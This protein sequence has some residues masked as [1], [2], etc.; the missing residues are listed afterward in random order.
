MSYLCKVQNNIRR[1]SEATG[2]ADNFTCQAL[3]K[4]GGFGDRMGDFSEHTRLKA[5]SP[6]VPQN[7]AQNWLIRSLAWDIDIF[8]QTCPIDVYIAD[9]GSQS[10]A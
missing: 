3:A 9:L 6:I 2:C 5:T 1:F 8:A 4:A 7:L 10:C